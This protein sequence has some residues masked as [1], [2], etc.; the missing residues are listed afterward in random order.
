MH[1]ADRRLVGLTFYT[2][3]DGKWLEIKA[4]KPATATVMHELVHSESL[5]GFN[6][7]LQDRCLMGMS[8][9]I[10]SSDEIIQGLASMKAM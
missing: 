5:L 3:H 8:L 1:I 7:R 6:F 10:A 9:N 2:E 4:P